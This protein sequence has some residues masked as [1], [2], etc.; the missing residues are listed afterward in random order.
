[1]PPLTVK[2][3]EPRDVQFL[4]TATDETTKPQVFPALQFVALFATVIVRVVS[5]LGT[6][7]VTVTV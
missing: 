7:G 1:M 3:I 6:E 5:Q 4:G 2:V